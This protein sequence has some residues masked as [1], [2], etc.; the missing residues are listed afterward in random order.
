MSYDRTFKQTNNRGYFFIYKDVKVTGRE[1]CQCPI[2][3]G[4]KEK[5]GS[6]AMIEDSYHPDNLGGEG[7]PV[8]GRLEI[9]RGVRSK[10]RGGG[11]GR[12]C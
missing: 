8:R 4:L 2:V 6:G 12:K 9:R 10:N 3:Q 5:V 11:G 1:C 7:A